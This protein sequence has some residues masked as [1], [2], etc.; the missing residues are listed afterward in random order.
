MH[1]RFARRLVG[2]AGMGALILLLVMLTPVPPVSAAPPEH[3]G[4]ILVQP[5]AGLPAARLAAIL[6]KHGATEL[7]VLH[8][9]DL[10]VVRVPPV[11]RERVVRA[12][13]HNPHIS[14]AEPDALVLP[15][16]VPNDPYFD[17]AW[18]LARV[19]APGAWDI[20]LG[21]N[22]VV[23]VLGTGVDASHPDLAGKVLNGYNVVSDNGDTADIHGHGTAVAGVVAA[24]SN[25]ALGVAS[26]AWNAMVLP[27]RI[28]NR[29][30]GRAYYS[31]IVDGL[32]WAADHGADVANLSY[33][34]V[35]GSA[36]V[37]SA[38]EYFVEHGGVV[39]VAAGNQGTDPGYAN[40]PYLIA[41]S[42][43][44]RSDELASW[45]SYGS[46]VD[47]AAPG[48]R[49]WTTT[50]DGGYAR[51]Y[52]TSF[53]SPIVAG[54]IAMMESANP[55]LAPADL[56]RLVEATAVDLGA[57]GYD[58][59]FGYGRVD[60][61]AAVAAAANSVMT[62]FQ[63][64]QT[65]ITA[66]AS[67]AT[68]SGPVRVDVVASDNRG[69]EQVTLWVNAAWFAV[70]DAPP[71]GFSWDSTGSADGETT[72]EI[73]ARD[74]A[75]NIGRDQVVVTV[76]NHQTTDTQPPS[77]RI[78][79]P[80]DGAN[81][82]GNIW[83]SARASDATGV[84]MLKLSVDGRLLCAGDSGQLTCRWNSRKVAPGM[85]TITAWAEDTAGNAASASVSVASQGNGPPG[86]RNRGK[87]IGHGKGR[88]PKR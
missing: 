80:D 14:F 38:A 6:H 81:V 83:V 72:L 86:H 69:V 18:H 28:T 43:T 73:A 4:R 62:D 29:E 19:D 59:H 25:N 46:Y 85:H 34:R 20:A 9:L 50:R 61:A 8:P 22:V 52:G 35:A 31:N 26:L 71:W 42:A 51:W 48:T 49:I 40:S 15:A 13:S 88:G 45:S 60:A 11:A 82:S 55:L 57:N 3:A 74:A 87:A 75:G 79:R 76:N 47:L 66:P 10:H 23:A 54:V 7:R 2:F 5:R 30:D 1:T 24:V 63:A 44:N 21:S 58:P 53:A 56:E 17:N 70:D 36:A 41:V 67:G 78:T 39:V 64:P 84:T 77:V 16:R 65:S 68:V 37:Q 27:V 32:L 12:L 33:N